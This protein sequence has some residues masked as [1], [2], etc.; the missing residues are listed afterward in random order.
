MAIF[1]GVLLTVEAINYSEE[2]N[3]VNIGAS[4]VQLNSIHAPFLNSFMEVKRWC[5]N[6][7]LI[8]LKKKGMS[9]LGAPISRLF[10]LMLMSDDIYIMMQRL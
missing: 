9:A 7:T 6:E 2:N 3:K 4:S 8:R 1:R 10:M 5:L